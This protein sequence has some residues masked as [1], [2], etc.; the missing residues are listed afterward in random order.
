MRLKRIYR[1]PLLHFL[2]IGATLFIAYSLSNEEGSVAPNRIVV[3]SGQVEQLSANFE[4]TRMRAP[5]EAEMAALIESHIREEVF[6]R[7]A[8][9]M[10]LD[11]DDPQVRRRMRMKLEFILE[12]ISS[13]NVTD[14]D[15]D[16][17]MK[18]HPDKFKSEIEIAFQQVYLNPEK[19]K[20]ITADTQKSLLL[21]N[22]GANPETLGDPILI[23]FN[24]ELSTQDEIARSFGDEFAK[25][26]MNISSKDWVGP[27][28]SAY[29]IHLV[30]IDKRKNSNQQN[31]AE[32]RKLVEREYLAERQKEQKDLAYNNLRKGYEVS[33]ESK[34]S[35]QVN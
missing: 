15:L 8:L 32:I 17:F 7:E 24:N 33:I 31:L 35:I 28:Y 6:Y 2:L 30:K 16:L 1:E 34:S 9:A 20:N 14:E 18:E 27:V 19:R 25:D 5:T 13:Q 23:P 4:R 10:G 29:G 12:D 11:Q 3:S 26:V 21:L 22:N